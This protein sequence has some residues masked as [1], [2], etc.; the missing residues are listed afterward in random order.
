MK[1]QLSDIPVNPYT[2]SELVRL[3]LRKQDVEDDTDNDGEEKSNI[4]KYYGILRY[5]TS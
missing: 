3:C 4:F 5:H 1:I 2:T